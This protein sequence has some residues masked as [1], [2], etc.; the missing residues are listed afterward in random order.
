MDTS[1]AQRELSGIRAHHC[2][3]TDYKGDVIDSKETTVTTLLAV[4]QCDGYCSVDCFMSA[5]SYVLFA[6]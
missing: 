3:C 5:L 2:S 6:P 1:V 4:C